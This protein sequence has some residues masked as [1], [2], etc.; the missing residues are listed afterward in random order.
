MIANGNRSTGGIREIATFYGIVGFVRFTEGYYISIITKR[1]P[2]AL[3]GGHYIFHV[4]GTSTIPIHASATP[5][6][7]L[8]KNSEELRYLQM[9][10][11]VD[12]SKNFYFSYSYDITRTLQWNMTRNPKVEGRNQ[13]FVW[14]QY[15]LENGFGE[16]TG[17]E[18][19]WALPIMYGFVEQSSMLPYP[20]GLVFALSHAV[21]E[22][23]S[24]EHHFL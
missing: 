5:M 13:M 18:N 15:L 22:Q 3:I 12:L 17:I 2:V 23:Y 14:N 21:K 1:S 6:S 11:M 20:A 9:F 4:D 10:R 16:Q 8:D 19:Q 7:K 24:Y